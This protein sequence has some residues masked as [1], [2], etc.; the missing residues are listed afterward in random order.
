MAIGMCTFGLGTRANIRT[1]SALKAAVNYHPRRRLP[2][3]FAPPME[4]ARALLC[5]IPGVRETRGGPRHW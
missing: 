5:A 2:F 1:A 4:S 3:F